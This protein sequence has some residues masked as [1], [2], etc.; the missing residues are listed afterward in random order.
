M[1]WTYR[2]AGVDIAKIK[3]AHKTAADF[4]DATLQYRKK[5]FGSVFKGAGHYAGLLNIGAGR[6]LAIHTDGVGTK[7]LIAQMMKR[8]DTVGI[9]CVAMN[10]NDVVCVGAEPFALVDY[11]AMKNANEEL[12]AEISKGLSEGAKQSK[13]AI[14]GG[15]TAILPDLLG[16]DENAFDLAA[17]CVGFVNK[18]KLI[19]GQKIKEGDVII[20]VESSGIHSNGLTLARKVLL[21]KYSVDD[22]IPNTKLRIGDEL[23]KPTQI[24]CR[25]ILSLIEDGFKITGLAHI[26]GGAFTKLQR[27]A[28]KKIGFSL[29][30][31]PIPPTIFSFIQ[32]EG[33]ISKDE[34]YKTFNMGVGLCIISPKSYSG[35]IVEALHEKGLHSSVIGRIIGK[36]GVFLDKRQLA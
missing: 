21:Q 7:V 18:D 30:K 9:D 28:P 35:K 4:F 34:M 12:V 32:K 16:G 26:T 22:K 13:V 6:L 24:Y 14:V 29:E 5:G 3:Q 31:M 2:E 20:G 8:F 33:N 19:L 1:K 36:P 27:I 15:E 25:Q 23:L 17:T 10:V 11:I